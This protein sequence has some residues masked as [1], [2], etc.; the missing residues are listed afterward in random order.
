[1]KIVVTEP[2]HLSEDVD[3][4][5]QGLGQVRYG[6]L[7]AAELTSAIEDCEV[8][9]VRLGHYIGEAVIASA[10]R[11]RYIVTATTGLDHVDLGAAAAHGVRVLSLRDCPRE[12]QAVSATAEHTWGLLLALVRDLPAAAAHV[13]AGGWN[14]DEFWG[15]QLQGKRLGVIGH[16]RIGK[17]VGGYGLAFGLDVVAYDTDPGRVVP[18]AALVPLT[19]LLATSDIISLH[20]TADPR[21]LHFLD[22]TLIDQIKRGAYFVNTARGTLVDEE[23]LADAV[24][25]GRLA[26]VAV[27]VLGGEERAI[28]ESNPL[29]RCAR[30]G[31][32]VLIT[33]HIGGATRESIA[34]AEQAV[35]SNLV[36]V[37]AMEK[38]S[39]WSARPSS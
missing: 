25:A 29:W 38:G 7:A 16:G 11:L 9:V 21:N 20:I 17:M 24:I 31:H 15:T 12:I 26:G 35:V 8:L 22:R 32:N 37:L 3:Q 13:Q 39:E 36:Q 28:P 4:M 6:P 30:A 18:P 2:L 27:D 33:P 1:M 34:R 14:R 10:P 19:E 5:L 23:G